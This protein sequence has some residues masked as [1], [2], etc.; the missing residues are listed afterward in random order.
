MSAKFVSANCAQ[1][2]NIKVFEIT[3]QDFFYVL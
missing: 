1:N 2:Y 3:T